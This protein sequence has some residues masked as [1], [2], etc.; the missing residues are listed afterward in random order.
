MAW[1]SPMTAVANT[2]LTAAQ[3]NTHVRDNLLETAPGKASAAGQTFVATAANAIAARVP[4]GATVIT[5]QATTSTSYTD[6]TTVGPSVTVTTGTKA[7]VCMSTTL[8][9]SG[10][11][12][13]SF[14]SYAVSGATT[15]AAA[16]QWSL[17]LDGTALNNPVRYGGIHFQES[18]NPG[19]NT[20][21]MKYKADA[22]SSASFANRHLFVFPL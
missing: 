1:T 18:L 19:S 10:T 22:T 11:S 6:L 7:I 16:D 5:S 15:I 13:G 3:W 12:F 17:I 20:F 14:A 4:T 8:L 21:T 9:N 2:A